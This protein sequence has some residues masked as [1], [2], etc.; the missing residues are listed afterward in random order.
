MGSWNNRED[1][2]GSQETVIH[3]QTRRLKVLAYRTNDL[4]V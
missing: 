3:R 4:G 1:I 2:T